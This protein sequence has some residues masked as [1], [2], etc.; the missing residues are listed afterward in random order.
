[1]AQMY[2]VKP[3]LLMLVTIRGK[4]PVEVVVVVDL[5]AQV[6]R[7]TLGH[8]L[9]TTFNLVHLLPLETIRT[10]RDQ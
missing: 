5:E 6:A 8:Q 7:A 10:R 2:L 4:V 3:H 9:L 1:M